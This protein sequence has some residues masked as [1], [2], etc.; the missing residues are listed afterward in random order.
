MDIE[1]VN[2]KVPTGDRPVGLDRA[3]NVMSITGL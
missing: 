1:I 3:P 2:D